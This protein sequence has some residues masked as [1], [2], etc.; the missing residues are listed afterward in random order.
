M[1]SPAP[2]G[3]DAEPGRC[4]ANQRRE[5]IPTAYNFNGNAQSI[6]HFLVTADIASITR[7]SPVHV[8]ADFPSI[9]RNDP[10]IPQVGSDHDGIVAYIKVPGTTVLSFNPTSVTFTA[11]QVVNTYQQ[12]SLSTVKNN[13][14]TAI[15]ITSIVASANFSVP[16]NPCGT[17]IV[18]GTPCVITVTFKPTTTGPITGTLTL[19]D[20]D[21]TG[22]QTV[23]LSG[24]GAGIFSATALAVSAG[25]S[26]FGANTTLTATVTGN[27][28]TTPTGSVNF[29]DGTTVLKSAAVAERQRSRHVQHNA[30]GRRKPQHHSGL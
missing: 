26:V 5:R 15:T 29:L 25:T 4:R 11:P 2:P 19:T 21:V 6:D 12:R 14:T 22:T 8:D 17:Q 24:T 20:S 16:A 7:T 9:D 1:S 23:N 18:A 10:T 28:G 13:G 3:R 27:A 30:A